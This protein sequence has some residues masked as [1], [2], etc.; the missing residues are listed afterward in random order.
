[1]NSADGSVGLRVSL[2]EDARVSIALEAGAPWTLRA[3]PAPAPIVGWCVLELTRKA[4]TLDE[5]T[6]QESQEL[7][8]ILSK[9]S[10]AVR[11]VTK[12]ERAYMTCFAQAYR[13]VH[14][15]IAPRHES[16]ARTQGWA[17]AD[18][19]RQVQSGSVTPVDQAAHEKTFQLI[20]QFL[21]A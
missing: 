6:S 5:L 10:A 15:H 3:H 20:A 12:C 8:L 18:L 13:Q 17:V 4:A 14:L 7:G 16:D 19:Y 2:G 1:M 9:V 11:H 21:G